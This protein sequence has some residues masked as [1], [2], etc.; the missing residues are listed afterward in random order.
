MFSLGN[1]SVFYKL[2]KDLDNRYFIP[3]L[4]KIDNIINIKELGSVNIHMSYYNII[5]F[6]KKDKSNIIEK[7]KKEMQSNSIVRDLMSYIHTN[8][9]EIKY[10]FEL[11]SKDIRFYFD[12]ETKYKYG[13][14]LFKGKN[15]DK[16][17]LYNHLNHTLSFGEYIYSIDYDKGY[18]YTYSINSFL[19][20]LNYFLNNYVSEF[21][22]LSKNNNKADILGNILFDI[23]EI[24]S[25]YVNDVIKDDLI[26]NYNID[27]DSI[28]SEYGE[29][30]DEYDDD[31]DDD[32]YDDDDDMFSFDTNLIGNLDFALDEHTKDFIFVYESSINVIT[33][34]RDADVHDGHPIG[35]SINV[36]K[37]NKRI[38]IRFQIILYIDSN[39]YNEFVILLND[40][41]SNK[42]KRKKVR[43]SDDDKSIEHYNIV[44]YKEI[45][46]D[47]KCEENYIKKIKEIDE[48]IKSML[49]EKT[50]ISY[51]N[52]T[53]S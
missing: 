52:N 12:Y 18:H 10:D 24:I 6:L 9:H 28:K 20:D 33:Y 48:H 5:S 47:Q 40:K 23:I 31:Y 14:P 2:K 29:Y 49:N 16:S 45:D 50:L 13:F 38:K 39:Y 17:F 22:S 3:T 37:H 7:D 51:I 36:A 4:Y 44:Y 53:V 21:L 1:K 46:C 27:T 43:K 8:D 30:E 15:V 41:K 11:I 19:S 26:F 42:K 32:D 25:Y 34:Y 35:F